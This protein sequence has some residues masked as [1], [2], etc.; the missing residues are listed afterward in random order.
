MSWKSNIKSDRSKYAVEE[1]KERSQYEIISL[2]SRKIIAEAAQREKSAS[3]VILSN[4]ERKGYLK[5]MAEIIIDS[6]SSKKMVVD[7]L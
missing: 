4:T 2:V 7:P 6:G 3:I 5:N 1:Y